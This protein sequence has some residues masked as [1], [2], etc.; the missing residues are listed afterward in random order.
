M[1][2]LSLLDVAC[3]LGFDAEDDQRN[4]WNSPALPD[5]VIQLALE[6]SRARTHL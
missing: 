3:L 2:I 4:C 6:V 5:N 1:V